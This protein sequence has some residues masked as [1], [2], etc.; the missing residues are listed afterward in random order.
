MQQGKDKSRAD[1]AEWLEKRLDISP[2]M[3]SGIRIELCGQNR[4][5]V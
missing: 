4:L 2:G 1:L 5:L 3:V